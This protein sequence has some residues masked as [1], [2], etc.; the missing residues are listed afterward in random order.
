MR[1]EG[2]GVL[3][4]KRLSEAEADG[5]RIWGLVLGTAINQ[6]GDQ[7]CTTGAQRPAQERVMEDALAR[8]GIDPSEVDYLE[9]H[10]TGTNLGDS[11]ELRASRLCLRAWAR[12]RTAAA[13]GLG[14]DQYR[15]LRVAA[16]MAS[17]I[18]SV[19]AMHKGV[20][21]AHLHF[22]E[23]NPNFD[24]GQM[25][26]RITSEQRPWP[27]H[28]GG[29]PLSAVNSF[30]LSGTNAHVVLE[31]YAE[32]ADGA[33]VQGNG[34]WPTGSEQTVAVAMPPDVDGVDVTEAERTG[35]SAR[36]LPLSARSQAT[37][38]EMAGKVPGVA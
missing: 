22:K 37:L 30:G 14:K 21:P 8:A 29:R 2:C 11:I 20:I 24:W 28:E 19:L 38:A 12:D 4:L 1:S 10:G 36:V 27:T 25:P 3:V 6:N 35:R 15:A 31:G 7:R 23:P 34:S 18:K 16:G 33:G 32:L 9:A 5:D 26:I 13:G 17:V